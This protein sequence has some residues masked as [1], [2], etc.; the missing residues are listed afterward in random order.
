VG[1]LKS[2]SMEK[3]RGKS[4]EYRYLFSQDFQNRE[5]AERKQIRFDGT[6][7]AEI[8]QELLNYGIK[9]DRVEVMI[10]DS[11]PQLKL[12]LRHMKDEKKRGREIRN[13]AG[14]I[15]SFLKNE[16]A[17]PNEK[18]VEVTTYR[19][20][21][22]I[23]STPE[24]RGYIRSVPTLD[25]IESYRQ[26]LSNQQKVELS[27]TVLLQCGFT[28]DSLSEETLV[29]DDLF[30]DAGPLNNPFL[31]SRARMALTGEISKRMGER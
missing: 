21:G 24:D 11:L 30:D 7:N 16:W 20:V 31:C 22:Q 6:A 2:V 8:S 15:Y 29:R 13:P 27:K 5:I 25:E 4:R 10:H 19:N 3:G 18:S 9:R 1:F 17:L 23:E 14:F 12:L 26:P 28:P